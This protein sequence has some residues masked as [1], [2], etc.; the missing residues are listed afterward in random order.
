MPRLWCKVINPLHTSIY[1]SFLLVLFFSLLKSPDDRF[2]LFINSKSLMTLL[3][4]ENGK[5]IR[6]IKQ[7]Y[8]PRVGE[9]LEYKVDK[10]TTHKK[11]IM[12][13]YNLDNE[14]ITISI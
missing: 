1:F 7:W 13:S 6:T 3:I 2:I 12:V 9:W 14:F 4:K 11:I 5:I 8:I 10:T